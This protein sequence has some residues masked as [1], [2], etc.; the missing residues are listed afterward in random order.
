VNIQEEYEGASGG[1]YFVSNYP[2]YEFWSDDALGGEPDV[3]SCASNSEAPLGLYVHV[4]FCRKRCHFCYYK[5]Y[6]NQTSKTVQGYV[7]A[8]VSEAK[9]FASRAVFEG[10]TPS[11]LY[12]GGG[13]P[14]YLSARQFQKMMTGLGDAF[15]LDELQEFTYECEPGTASYEKFK[16]L[17]EGGVSRV[18]LG[19][20]HFDDRVLLQNGRAHDQKAIY[21]AYEHVR[22]A[23]VPQVNI[24]LIAGM[25]GDTEEGWSDAVTR[26]LD[27]APD[28][29][30][31]YQLEFPY[32]T[33][34]SR[35][36]RELG[37]LD[38][39]VPDWETKRRWVDEAFARLE[40]NGYEL[41]SGYTAVKKGSG[42]TFLY[43]DNLWT[44]ADLLGLGVSSFSQVGGTHFQNE[45]HLE[46][47][48]E[49]I[50]R[51][52]FAVRRGYV[53]NKEEQLIR[54]MVLQLKRG[55][56]D[57]A[58][59]QSKF[60]VSI[61]EEYASAFA[62]LENAGHGARTGELFALNRAS[63]LQVDR[64]LPVFFL[65]EHRKP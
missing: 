44:G 16:A 22:K 35:T 14:S 51:G 42:A 29:V 48:L 13:T 6:T 55:R 1:N 31:I 38:G 18:S 25:V 39:G 65:P 36:L 50:G 58:Y 3:L 5:V 9:L 46:G 61:F 45:K 23:G 4:P 28:S 8:L 15:S 7:D 57:G 41:G 30:T 60:A 21:K 33:N 54:E 59:F 64:L 49:T 2:G 26:T 32:N 27:M 19:L 47:Y 53:M 12:V 52:A 37:S 24:D 20:E 17:K 56:L 63:F 34:F 43:R 40:A 11:F 62:S 10:R